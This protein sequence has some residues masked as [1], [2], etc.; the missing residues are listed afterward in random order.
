VASVTGRNSWWKER[1]NRLAEPFFV[2]IFDHGNAASV[3][4]ARFPV[5]LLPGKYGSPVEKR[6]PDAER[7]RADGVVDEVADKSFDAPAFEHE[8]HGFL[9][10]EH[11]VP[12]KAS[13]PEPVR[14]ALGED[15]SCSLARAWQEPGND[16]E[17]LI[18]AMVINARRP[19]FPPSSRAL[20]VLAVVDERRGTARNG[21]M[22]RQS[23][24]KIPGRR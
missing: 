2:E 16:G 9:G 11:A 18:L 5:E 14:R 1:P 6:S 12:P 10:E 4:L 21:P 24:R 13:Q 22:L 15:L 7:G 20:T 23:I 8:D 19:R 3:L 17:A